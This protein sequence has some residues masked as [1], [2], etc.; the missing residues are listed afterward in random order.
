MNK[1]QPYIIYLRNTHEFMIK[2]EVIWMHL[3]DSMIV[4]S[5]AT[6][7]RCHRS[8]DSQRTLQ[9]AHCHTRC[10]YFIDCCW[11][12]SGG[13]YKKTIAVIAPSSVGSVPVNWLLSSLLCSP[14]N[15]ETTKPYVITVVLSS[16]HN[17]FL[18]GYCPVQLVGLEPPAQST[19]RWYHEALC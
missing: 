2:C 8:A 17:C 5:S 13:T 3:H 18:G 11:R 1:K 4:T 7:S 6:T 12:R 14:S 10:F 15:D 16:Y 9:I 19:N